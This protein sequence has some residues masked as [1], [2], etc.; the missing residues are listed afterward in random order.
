MYITIAVGF[1]VEVGFV[2]RA[3]TLAPFRPTP[4]RRRPPTAPTNSASKIAFPAI[5]ASRTPSNVA[6][7]TPLPAARSFTA[8]WPADPEVPTGQDVARVHV[9]APG[10]CTPTVASSPTL[11]PNGLYF[12]ISTFWVYVGFVAPTV[13][14]TGFPTT[15][16]TVPNRGARVASTCDDAK[17]W[18][19][20]SD[21]DESF[22]PPSRDR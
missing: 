4:D 20:S 16:T 22:R 17:S 15:D 5:A 9:P 11:F 13:V 21:H 19:N 2:N 12:E 1:T 3:P 8:S 6:R 18:L 7:S 10:H 14:L